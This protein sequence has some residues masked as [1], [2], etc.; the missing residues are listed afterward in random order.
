M[1]LLLDMN[2]AARW[3]EHLERFG[4]L[5]VHWSSVGRANSPDQEILLYARTHECVVITQDLDFGISL[6]VSGAA[7]PSVIQL[8][9]ENVGPEAIGATVV[10]ACRNM[11][12]ELT[13]GALLTI[14]PQKIRISSLPLLR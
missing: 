11:E 3:V 7:S 14:D 10:Y 4:I 2:M 1:K 12:E 6:A 5:A 13:R 9:T 8:R